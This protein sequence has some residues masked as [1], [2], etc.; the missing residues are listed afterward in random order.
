MKTRDS[1]VGGL[2]NEWREG[3]FCLTDASCF[4]RFPRDVLCFLS[5]PHFSTQSY[6]K[7]LI[8]ELDR[9]AEY[10]TRWQE[11]VHQIPLQ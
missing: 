5:P 10:T 8:I 1:Q 6:T 11:L 9:M 3:Q 4:M 7:I 2:M